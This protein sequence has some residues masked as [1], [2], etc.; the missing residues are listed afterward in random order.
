V[1]PHRITV[2]TCGPSVY[3]HSHIGNFR[4]FLFEDILVRYLEFSGY[5]VRRGITFTDVE[6]KAILEANRQGIPLS[7]L[8]EKNIRAF[9][10]EMGALRMK[11]P[12]CRPKASE[13]VEEAVQ[14]IHSLMDK[15][16]A[17][18]HGKNVYFDPLKF[19]AFGELYGLDMRRW[20]ASKR[21]FHKDTYPGMRWNRGDFI[22]WHGV[23]KDSDTGWDA[24]F[25]RGRPSW[26]VQDPSMILQCFDETL[27]VYCGGVDNL[28][29]HH[30]Y[31]KAILESIR[32]YPM[33]RYWLHGQHLTAGGKKIS[34]SLGN[35]IYTD[36]LRRKGYDYGQI[37]FFLL[38]THYRKKHN[39]SDSRMEQSARRL[40][41]IRRETDALKKAAGKVAGA[42]REAAVRLK[43]LFI[44][45]MDRDLDVPAA[46]DA[47][48]DWLGRSEARSAEQAAGAWKSLLEI[49]EVLQILKNGE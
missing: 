39:Y 13:A 11:L 23:F 27:S 40:E 42:D 44:E 6:D 19:P 32:P 17:Y 5:T 21:R 14:I 34:K 1:D 10:E 9:L 33:A 45:N 31:N 38:T 35:V 30:D 4:T 36:D 29:R 7:E 41:S 20:P 26:N 49:D 8:T 3:Q 25:G 12:D 22:L 2:F 47:L 24:P 46:L 15:G 28:I 18:R 43:R 48:E 37:R 16:L